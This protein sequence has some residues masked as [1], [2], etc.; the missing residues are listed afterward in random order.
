MGHSLG[1]LGAA[2][3]AQR[4]LHTAGRRSRDVTSLAEVSIINSIILGLV[5]PICNGIL[6]MN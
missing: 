5:Y 4:L 1:F 2:V 6:F 3:I